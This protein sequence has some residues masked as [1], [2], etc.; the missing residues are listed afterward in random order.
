MDKTNH[1]FEKLR[2]RVERLVIS[3]DVS[4]M[5]ALTKKNSIYLNK[6]NIDQWAQ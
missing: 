4:N 5:L 6:R 2:K 3:S 1:Q